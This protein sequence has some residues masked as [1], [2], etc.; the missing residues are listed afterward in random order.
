MVE[1]NGELWYRKIGFYNNPF[2]IKPAPYDF[3][4]VGQD[5]ILDELIYKIPAGTMTF[6]EG[7]LGTGKSTIMK[8]LI[9]KFKGKGQVI[10]FSCNRID[11]E[12]NIEEMLL[13]KY[14]FWG[15]LMGKHPKNMI[16]LLDEAQELTSEN[17]ERIKYF[18]DAGN[19][20]SVVFVGTDYDNVKLHE[21]I[22]ERIGQDGVLRVKQLDESEAV[23]L[24]RNRL[25]NMNLLSDEHIKKL[26]KLANKNPRRLLQRCDRAC[27]YVIETGER[28]F[29]DE[30]FKKLFGEEKVSVKKEEV[31]KEETLKKKTVKKKVAPKAPK[32]NSNPKKEEEEEEALFEVDEER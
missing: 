8:H 6:I 13:N 7:P 9:H 18:F 29:T 21:S 2:S 28:E 31:K 22:K 5:E 12:L 3:K 30:H 25:G 26:F 24:V 10:F 15:K 4:V 23:S 11:N 32:K 14:G 20:K 16:L 1:E 27:R 17:T 19:I